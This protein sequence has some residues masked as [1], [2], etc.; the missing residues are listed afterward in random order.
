MTPRPFES[1]ADDLL[2]GAF[3]D[4]GA[5]RQSGLPA[6]V[7]AHSVRVGLVGTDADGDFGAVAG[8][9][10][11]GDGLGGPPSVQLLLDPVQPQLL[12]AFAQRRRLRGGSRA[13]EGIALVED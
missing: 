10:Q 7:V 6:G 9:L 12:F 2:A 1:A 11:S 3:H 13:I 8:R 4:A 5:G